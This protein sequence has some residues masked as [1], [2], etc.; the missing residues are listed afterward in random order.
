MIILSFNIHRC[1]SDVKRNPLCLLIM[2]ED[3]D[4]C[5]LQEI[6]V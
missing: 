6:K 4:I 3:F 1:D 2:K 5:F